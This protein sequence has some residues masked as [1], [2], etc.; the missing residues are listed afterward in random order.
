MTSLS[1]P[2]PRAAGLRRDA[3]ANRARILDVAPLLIAQRG[4]DLSFHELARRAGVGVATVY[5][6]FPTTDDLVRALYDTL[7]QRL[8]L[9][10][11]AVRE[12]PD[13][14]SGIEAYVDGVAAVLAERPDGPRVMERMR[15]LDPAYRPAD[16]MRAPM[17]A[18][19]ARAHAEGTLRED[20]TAA[21]IALLPFGL[22]S[23]LRFPEPE[24][25]VILRR[26]RHILLE[27]LR[28][29]DRRPMPGSAPSV[30]DIDAATHH[31][32]PAR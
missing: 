17:A 1:G 10:E 29:G 7:Y 13:G 31:Q 12:A 26:Q 24:G 30:D 32:H 16:A 19:A 22:T 11:P 15:E 6:N 23:V 9:I 5:R 20:V 27:G 14:W 3:A 18:M 21:D 28:A 8:A 2:S 4:L 25:A